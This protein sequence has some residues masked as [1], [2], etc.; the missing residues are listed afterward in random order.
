MIKFNFDISLTLVIGRH[1]FRLH[2]ITLSYLG[3]GGTPFC[4]LKQR[5]WACLGPW[6]GS[7]PKITTFTSRS[8]QWCVQEYTCSAGGKIVDL[9][10]SPSRKRLSCVYSVKISPG[11]PLA[12]HRVAQRYS[13]IIKNYTITGNNEK[14]SRS[15]YKITG[16]KENR[17][18]E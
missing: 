3:G 13:M 15:N 4:T 8:S 16:N 6:Y 14:L 9:L 18:T 1:F 5:P 12:G 17:F 2:S 7:W 10:R 11:I